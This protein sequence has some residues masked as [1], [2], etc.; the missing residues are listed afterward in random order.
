[1]RFF[2]VWIFSLTV[3]ICLSRPVL[4]GVDSMNLVASTLPLT[5]SSLVE[6]LSPSAL[7]RAESSSLIERRKSRASATA[8][9]SRAGVDSFAVTAGGAGETGLLACGITRKKISIDAAQKAAAAP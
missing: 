1:M 9:S 4:D 7:A 8:E 5:L 6:K 3:P 2:S